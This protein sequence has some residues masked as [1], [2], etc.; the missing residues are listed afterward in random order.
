MLDIQK[1]LLSQAATHVV[2]SVRMVIHTTEERGSSIFAD[3]L[4][5]EMGTSRMLVNEIRNIMNESRDED[6]RSFSSLLLD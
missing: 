3:E 4:D 6:E 5:Q 1:S 2:G